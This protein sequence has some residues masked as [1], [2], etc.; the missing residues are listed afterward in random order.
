MDRSWKQKL[1]KNTVKLAEV[2]NQM[3]LTESI[4]YSIP[5][6]KNIPSFQQLIVPFPT[7]AMLLV[8]KQVSIDT[9][10]LK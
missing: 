9:R 5:K 10:R 4:E 3:D 1:N 6:E 7:L 2:M 8:T